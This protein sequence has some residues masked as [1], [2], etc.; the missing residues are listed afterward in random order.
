M[1]SI[2]TE[3]LYFLCFIICSEALWYCWQ[4]RNKPADGGGHVNQKGSAGAKAPA[5]GQ[6]GA[7]KTAQKSG[8]K[9]PTAQKGQVKAQ[10]KVAVATTKTTAAGAKKNKKG[11]RHQ[12]HDLLVT[13]DLVSSNLC[14]NDFL[15]LY[16]FVSSSIGQYLN[17]F[18]GFKM[19]VTSNFYSHKEVIAQH[20]FESSKIL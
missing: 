3:A 6:K 19:V 16:P 11:Q 18:Q 2:G 7:P 13:I 5:P 14:E 12:Q 1:E 4:A 15:T 20:N 10:P 8:Q 17:R 9:P